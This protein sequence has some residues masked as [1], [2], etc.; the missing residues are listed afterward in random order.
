MICTRFHDTNRSAIALPEP[1]RE[2]EPDAPI[3]DAMVHGPNYV[4][5][6]TEETIVPT[7]E[8]TVFT[9]LRPHTSVDF[10]W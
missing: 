8:K 2:R 6:T 5:R 7:P 3:P 1:Q 4:A 9:W 10:E